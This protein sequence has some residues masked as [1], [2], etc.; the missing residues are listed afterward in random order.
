MVVAS[1]S[2]TLQMNQ[3]DRQWLSE[4]FNDVVCSTRVSLEVIS[5][6]KVNESVL[7]IYSCIVALSPVGYMDD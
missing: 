6:Y 1:L 3:T 2:E 7:Y 4:I 5:S